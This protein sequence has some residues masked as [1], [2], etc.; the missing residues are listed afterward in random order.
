M[1]WDDLSSAVFVDSPLVKSK[2]YFTVGWA[3]T[4]IL[5]KSDT[6]VEVSND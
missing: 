6:M 3:I 4:W 2:Q 5:D 1:K